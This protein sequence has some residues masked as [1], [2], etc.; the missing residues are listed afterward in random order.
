MIKMRCW[1]GELK[2]WDD[3]AYPIHNGMNPLEVIGFLDDNDHEQLIGD[4]GNAVVLFTGV[5]DRKG[6]EIYVGDTFKDDENF[7]WE[8]RFEDG[9]FEIVCDDLMARK[10]IADHKY[11]TGIYGNIFESK[12]E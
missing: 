5:K 6:K 4:E 11:F 3:C 2:K 12:E 7:I 8:V 1:N 9:L 10:P